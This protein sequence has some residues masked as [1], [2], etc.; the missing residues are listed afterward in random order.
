MFMS[1]LVLT[2]KLIA[3]SELLVAELVLVKVAGQPLV[4]ASHELGWGHGAPWVKLTAGRQPPGRA[5][6]HKQGL[7]PSGC[8]NQKGASQPGAERMRN[9]SGRP[10]GVAGSRAEFLEQSSAGVKVVGSAPWPETGPI[11]TV[12]SFN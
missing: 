9:A 4:P 3:E 2:E 5:P 1:F 12:S 10:P 6:S 8:T 7:S 11:L